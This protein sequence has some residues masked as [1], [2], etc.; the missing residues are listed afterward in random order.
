MQSP[1]TP[2]RDLVA[3]PGQHGTRARRVCRARPRVN[4]TKPERVGRVVIGLVGV[5]AGA[6]LLVSSGSA[7]VIVLE[8]L[9]VVAGID[10]VITGALGHCPLYQKLGHVPASLRR[11]T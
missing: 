4:I 11:P 8:I 6:T 2:E 10:L 9:L 7:L 5:V 3:Q 1:N